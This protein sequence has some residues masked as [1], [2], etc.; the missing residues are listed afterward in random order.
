M[1]VVTPLCVTHDVLELLD[2]ELELELELESDRE[3]SLQCVTPLTVVQELLLED[4]EDDENNENN[5]FIAQIA[6]ANK[7]A[8][9]IAA[10]TA[11]M[12]SIYILS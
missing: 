2:E 1:Q 10:P 11:R 7:K 6:N 9:N 4:D 8:P 12:V 3:L 5:D